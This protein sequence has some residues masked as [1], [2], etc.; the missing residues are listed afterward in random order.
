MR[1]DRFHRVMSQ[2]LADSD[3]A[4][5]VQT[6][7]EAEYPKRFGHVLTLED[8]SRVWVQ[9]VATG[10]PGGDNHNEP[11]QIPEETRQWEEARGYVSGVRS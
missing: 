9:Y 10:P 3:V 2:L 8:G 11:E 1:L 5:E 4:T 6:F 7:E